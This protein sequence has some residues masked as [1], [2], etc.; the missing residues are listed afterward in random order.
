MSHL[1]YNGTMDKRDLPII[2]SNALITIA[3][4]QNI[5]AKIDTGADSSSVWASDILVNSQNQLEFCLFAPSSPLYT[6]EKLT[7]DDFSVQRVRNSTGDVS[8]RYRVKLPM[9]AVGKRIKASFTLADRS[10]NN[11]PVL[12]GRKT[13][14]DRFLVDVAHTEVERPPKMDNSDL[15]SE[16][17]TDPHAFHQKYMSK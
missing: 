1:C 13:L 15:Q 12:L 7:V 14:K 5:P 11:F 9:I 8:V 10:R 3:G 16:L 17:S 4:I 2:G 6:G